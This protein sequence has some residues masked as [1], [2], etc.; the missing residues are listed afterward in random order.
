MHR[1]KQEY[2]S[3]IRREYGA[4][5]GG[6]KNPERTEAVA[7]KVIALGISYEDY[8]HLAVSINSDW[9]RT[10][11]WK[12]PYWGLVSSDS[13][14]GRV[15]SMLCYTDVVFS[16]T[17]QQQFLEEVEYAASYLRWFIGISSDKPKRLSKV[18]TDV[19]IAVA[20][21]LCEMY[22]VVCYSSNYNDIAERL[23][24]SHDR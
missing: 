5:I 7:Q 17:H 11:G 6:D 10:K 9:A 12:Y 14:I 16:D 20:E 24:D 1:L 19:K 22:G 18:S 3:Y 2:N 23:M 15:A 13:T 8:I 4:G 21:Y